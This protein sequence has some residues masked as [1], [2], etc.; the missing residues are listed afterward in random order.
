MNNKKIT[1]IGAGNSGLVMAAHLAYH[2]Y[3]ICLW[4]RSKKTID[5]ILKTKTIYLNVKITAKVKL[6]NVTTSI[7]EALKDSGI[8]LITT[9]ANAHY[10]LARI[11]SP[12][13]EKDSTIILNPGRTFGALEFLNTLISENCQNIPSICETQTIIYTCRKTAEDKV[14][15]L[16]FKNSVL[17]SC[18]NNK[19]EDILKN[20][21]LELQK[22]FKPT[23]NFLRT[24]LGNVGMILHCAP[25]LLNSGWIE[26]KKHKFRYYYEGITPSIAGFLEKID[27]ERLAVASKFGVKIRSVSQ[28]LNESYDVHGKNLYE[29]I[30]QVESY[31]TIDA[32]ESLMHRYLFE[33]I[34]TGLVPIEALGKK[35]GLEMKN[36]SLIIDLATEML[37]YDFRFNGR[38]AEK[39]KL[40]D[41]NFNC[42]KLFNY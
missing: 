15:L 5:K 23:E 12:Y 20:L 17:I 2:G 8:I 11:M 4:N 16:A 7:Q 27:D 42:L 33:D 31:R 36:T 6:S 25:V 29:S 9:P 39:L 13:I 19:I 22:Y 30:Q 18:I 10:D 14:S 34:C 37:N 41:K 32:P 38:N 28:W 40:I 35:L 26:N 3:N 21:P 24:S 1:V